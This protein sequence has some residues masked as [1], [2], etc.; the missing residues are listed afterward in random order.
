MFV[1]TTPAVRV[2]TPP[3][4]DPADG[5]ILMARRA[6]FK[7]ELSDAASVLTCNSLDLGAALAE[8][9][10][11]PLEAAV[12]VVNAADHRLSLGRRARR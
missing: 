9:V 3:Q 6:F 7:L 10:L 12:E 4:S 1:A 11:D 2:L 5:A 8:L